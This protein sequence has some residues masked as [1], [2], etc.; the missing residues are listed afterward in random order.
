MKKFVFSLEKVLDYKQQILN[1]L[2]NEFA[3]LQM[4]LRDIIE[5]IEQLNQQ[6]TA[7]NLQ[8]QAEIQEGLS[9]GDIAV[10]KTYLQALNSK[11]Q[12]LIQ[13]KIQLQNAV[14]QK[15]QEVLVAKS[16]IS[17]LEK[18]KD[19]QLKEYNFQIQKI[20]EQS[21]EEFV[22]HARSAG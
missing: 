17:G 19:K 13:T 14:E 12:K 2:K 1:V 7:L 22:S 16:E 10:Y 3:D 21:I 20:Q 11:T 6:F 4:K 15:K 8:M 9:A 18:L 5:Q